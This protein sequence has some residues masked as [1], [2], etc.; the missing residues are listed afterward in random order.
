MPSVTVKLPVALDK[1][2]RAAARRR[3]EKISVLAR[4]AIER[5]V[6]SGGPDFATL[7]E[8]YKGMMRGPKDLSSREGY[9]G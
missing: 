6:A 5:E 1:K 2:V 3:G 4:R 7:A 9:G 8:R